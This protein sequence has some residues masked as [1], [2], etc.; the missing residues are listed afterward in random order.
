MKAASIESSV[1]GVI[2]RGAARPCAP[3]A[4]TASHWRNDEC[5]PVEPERARAH[6]VE[7]GC[8]AAVPACD[9]RAP[10]F[11][12]STPSCGPRLCARPRK[13]RRIDEERPRPPGEDA[14]AR[15]AGLDLHL[16]DL[17]HVTVRERAQDA[18]DGARTR[19]RPGPWP[20]RAAGPGP[21]CCPRR[22]EPR[23]SRCAPPRPHAVWARSGPRPA[24]RSPQPSRPAEG[25]EPGRERLPPTRCPSGAGRTGRRKPHPPCPGR[26]SRSPPRTTTHLTPMRIRAQRR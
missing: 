11:G 12:F 6:A 13:W 5:D 24:G 20:R 18:P 9:D 14:S 16:V 21:R 17:L 2:G 1:L 23:R 25:P 15:S 22:P 26:R 10:S 3:T 8:S 7:F 19:P 4:L